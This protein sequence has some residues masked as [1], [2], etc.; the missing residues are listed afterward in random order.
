[1][2]PWHVLASWR[3]QSSLSGH[4]EVL[5]EGHAFMQH[6]AATPPLPYCDVST[7]PLSSPSSTL[8]SFHNTELF[9]RPRQTL[10]PAFMMHAA[11]SSFTA[12][13][14]PVTTPRHE[15]AS[16]ATT[17]VLPLGGKSGGRG[18]KCPTCTELPGVHCVN[19]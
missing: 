9:R 7:P 2:R 11:C 18:D 12:S 10:R 4:L 14:H 6:L 8:H 13:P 1:M 19:K 16:K 3:Q 15:T 5:V 17:A